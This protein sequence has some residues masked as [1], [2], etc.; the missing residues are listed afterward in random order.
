MKEGFKK[1]GRWCRQIVRL[2]N[3]AYKTKMLKL[4][5]EVQQLKENLYQFCDITGTEV[6]KDVLDKKFEIAG[7]FDKQEL[8][9]MKKQIFNLYKKA[10]D[11]RLSDIGD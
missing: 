6:K 9:E 1:I 8:L 7:I 11:L 4:A 2:A 5:E 10:I 3:P